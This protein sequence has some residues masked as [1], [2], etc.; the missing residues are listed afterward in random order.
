MKDLNYKNLIII[1]VIFVVTISI[2][3][4]SKNITSQFKNISKQISSDRSQTMDPNLP[5]PGKTASDNFTLKKGTPKVKSGIYIDR[6]E[7]VDIKNSLWTY[8]FYIWFSWNPS[9]INFY[10]TNTDSYNEL[11]FSVI[12]GEIVRSRVVDKYLNHEDSISYVQYSVKANNTHSFDVSLY[13]MDFH[14]LIISIEHKFLNREQLVFIPDLQDTKASS[15]INIS[16]YKKGSIKIIEKPHAYKSAR[17]NPLLP[18][19]YKVDFSQLRMSLEISPN[20]ISTYLK[21]FLIMYLSAVVAFISPFTDDPGRY[22][23]GAL[24]TTAGSNL[25]LSSQLPSTSVITLAEYVNGITIGTITLFV[26]LLAV[27]P[28]FLYNDDKKSKLGAVL[29]KCLF[30]IIILLYFILNYNLL[31]TVF[32]GSR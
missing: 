17:G 5:D 24:F 20:G 22:V 29:Y 3:L 9:E 15:R 11:P 30:L 6:I 26:V 31:S 10:G 2:I 19:G 18:S 23:V 7:Q 28:R 32:Y 21:I 27:V 12:N 14:D 13:P 1:A 8:E 4:F 16:G 25:V